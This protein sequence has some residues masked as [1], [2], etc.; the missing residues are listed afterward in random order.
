MRRRTTSILAAVVALFALAAPAA[1][2][3][4]ERSTFAFEFTLEDALALYE[5]FDVYDVDCGDFHIISTAVG[6]TAITDFGDRM[7]RHVRF[8]GGYYNASDPTK[9]AVRIGNTATWREF[10][11]AGEWTEVHIHG[12]Q[13]MAVLPDGRHVPIDVGY[14]A[15]D[16]ITFETLHQA[17]QHDASVLCDALR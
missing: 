7:L 5:E 9:Y 3:P 2:A 16:M 12:I 10:D 14:T 6:E 17:G 4:P 15:G 11:D 8:T 1:A 13:N